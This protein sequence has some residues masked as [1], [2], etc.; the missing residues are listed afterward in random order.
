MNEYG[1]I[2]TQQYK[3]IDFVRCKT[4]CEAEQSYQDYK[5]KGYG[6]VKVKIEKAF[7][8]QTATFDDKP[9]TYQV[10]VCGSN[11]YEITEYKRTGS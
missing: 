10:A 6:V 3:P 11:G 1:V 2:V 9:D 7:E 8:L 4:E 5:S